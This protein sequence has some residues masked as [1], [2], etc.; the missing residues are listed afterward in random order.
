M[1]SETGPRRVRLRAVARASGALL[2]PAMS[3][4]GALGLGAL[5]LAALGA[6]AGPLI[7]A[8]VRRR[9][10]LVGRRPGARR[11]T[12]R[13]RPPRSPGS[14]GSS[15]ASPTRSQRTQ[16]LAE[17]AADAFYV[18]QQEYFDAA[19]RADQLQPQ[20]DAAGGEGGGCR[21]QGR[22]RR[23]AALPQR[24]RRHLARAVLLGLGRSAPTTCSRA[25]ARWTS[26]SSATRRSTPRRSPRATPRRA[27]A[28]RPSSP[29]TSATGCSRIAEQ[30]MVAAQQAADAAQAALD[31]QH[32]AP[33]RARRRSSPR[34][35]TRPPR[36]SPTTRQESR[37]RA[38]RE[39]QRQ[40]AERAEA[41]RARAQRAAAQ[42][43]R[44]RRRR[45]RRWRRRRRRR[46][47][48]RLG[49]AVVRLAH[50]GLRPAH[51]AVRQ[52]ATARADSTTAS[53][54]RPA[55]ARGSTRPPPARVVY[56]GYNGGYGNYIKIDHGG[57]IGTGYG[58][59]PSAAG[60][61]VGYGQWVNAG[62]LIASEG[63]T[64]NSF[65]CHLHFETYV[66]RQPGEPRSTSW[67]RA[68]ISV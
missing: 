56:A 41:E 8:G 34:C 24:R 15:Q 22:P 48:L 32:A 12:R 58:A 62:E 61:F 44:W 49:A 23:R 10:S 11:R 57:G 30:K 37:P 52:R 50:L 16:A 40:A 47:R 42:R 5:G 54:S 55:A 7:P 35:R 4:R 29:A 25:S 20:A 28:T 9:L 68:G 18:A 14:R 51:R 17:Q 43:R 59:H 13:P 66:E 33:G 63:N 53:T 64:G 38:S 67:P 6:L 36:R 2:W 26:S 27:S 46:R 65:G 3:R 45:R 31:E 21:E 1:E 60:I 39:E 19:Y